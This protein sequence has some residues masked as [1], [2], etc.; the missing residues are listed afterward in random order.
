MSPV[1]QLQM[2]LP[3]GYPG[4]VGGDDTADERS[5]AWAARGAAGFG[6][7][8]ADER[9]GGAAFGAWGPSG[10]SAVKGL[11]HRRSDGSD[12]KAAR[13]SEQSTKA[14]GASKRGAG[15]HPRALLGFWADFGRREV[16]RG[17][18]AFARSR[19][20]AVMD[21]RGWDLG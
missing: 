10:V 6:S 11:P 5:G 1:C 9:G 17:A 21:D 13:L 18:R 3:E 19:D 7:S 4:G 8:A 12:L 16:A 2:T 14:R 15:N 20:A